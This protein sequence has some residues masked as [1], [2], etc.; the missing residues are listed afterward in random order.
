MREHEYRLCVACF[1]F[2][3]EV[4]A[5]IV[6]RLTDACGVAAVLHEVVLVDNEHA[7]VRGV[8][9]AALG[10]PRYARI[11]VALDADRT[12]NRGEDFLYC[13]VEGVEP[14]LRLG[15]AARVVADVV[16][17]KEQTVN[18]VDAVVLHLIEDAAHVLSTALVGALLKVASGD[19]VDHVLLRRD[20]SAERKA[21][22]DKREH[23]QQSGYPD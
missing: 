20:R 8:V 7:V 19:D 23:Q 21:H 10:D 13:R 2:L 14:E 9:V 11:V 22:R 18:A 17:A 5:Q 1:L 3:F 12:L 6:R 4:G 15:R 16:A